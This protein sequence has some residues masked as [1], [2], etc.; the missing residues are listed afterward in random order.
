MIGMALR[1]YYVCKLGL[2]D[3]GTLAKTGL[4]SC[5]MH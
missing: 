1:R 3:G 5:I 4:L 2:K